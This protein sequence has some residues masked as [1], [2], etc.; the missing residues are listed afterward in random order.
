MAE[1]FIED[2]IVHD[3]ILSTLRLQMQVTVGNNCCTDATDIP[4]ITIASCC[5][6]QDFVISGLEATLGLALDT[7]RRASIQMNYGTL[8]AITAVEASELYVV[9]A[10]ASGTAG[11]GI[12]TIVLDS[13]ALDFSTDS[14]TDAVIDLALPVKNKD[15]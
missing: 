8:G 2:A 3:R 1:N 13:A 12:L 4:G 10:I 11:S 5:C 6:G 7:S 9:S 15:F 14:F